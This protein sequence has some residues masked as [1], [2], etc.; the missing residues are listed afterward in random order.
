M[1]NVKLARYLGL[2][3]KGGFV[4]YGLDNIKAIRV[5]RGKAIVLCNTAS[6]RTHDS[7]VALATERGAKLIELANIT[8]D[9]LIKTN[10]CKV[11]CVV[12]KDLAEV[13]NKD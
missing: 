5:L 2:A 8:L 4:V 3:I 11:I 13:I 7:I 9:E 10:N 6:K 12:N 1:D